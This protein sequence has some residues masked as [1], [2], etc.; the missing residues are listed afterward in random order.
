MEAV[1]ERKI[2]CSCRESKILA[3]MPVTRHYSDYDT[4]LSNVN[5]AISASVF[6]DYLQVGSSIYS[7][8]VIDYDFTVTLPRRWQSEHLK[9]CAYKILL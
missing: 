3:V 8:N 9:A 1:E 7:G 2:S 6:W 5:I 4:P